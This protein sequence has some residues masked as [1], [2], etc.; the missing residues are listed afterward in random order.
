MVIGA[1]AGWVESHPDA[2]WGI[3]VLLALVVGYLLRSKD[4]ELSS[5]LEKI[6]KNQTELFEK[7]T[8]HE[9]RLA[10][11]EGEHTARVQK[12]DTCASKGAPR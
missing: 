11:L 7:L 3:V 8:A 1:T 12:G 6:D 9:T 5:T 4:R 2:V 10:H